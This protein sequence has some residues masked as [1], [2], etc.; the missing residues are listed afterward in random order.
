MKFRC[1]ICFGPQLKR[2]SRYFR[3]LA[4]AK[5]HLQ[6]RKTELGDDY[7]GAAIFEAVGRRFMGMP[8]PETVFMENYR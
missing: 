1:T 6:T 8:V 3:T 7:V 5:R 4:Q 2:T